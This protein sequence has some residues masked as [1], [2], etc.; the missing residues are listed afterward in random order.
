[1]EVQPTPIAG[2]WVIVPQVFQDLR[3]HLMETF[4]YQ[5][6]KAAGLPCHFVQDNLSFSTRNTLRGLHFQNPHGQAKLV[7]AVQG[8]VFDVAV[9]IRVG[10]PTF[11]KWFGLTLSDANQRQLLIAAGI[12]HG[13]CVLS[14]TAHVHYK[15]T[16]Y[17]APAH[18]GGILWSD[19]EIG[20]DW[21]L[22]NPLLSDKDRTY[23]RL[24][25]LPAAILPTKV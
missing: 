17:Y 9:D 22:H 14:E 19:P 8:E 11:G 1:M 7:Q 12:A 20:I 4:Q 6:F 25:D 23:P 24:K 2:V 15:C 5:R 18:E 3:G 13:F 16:D 10:S 21:P